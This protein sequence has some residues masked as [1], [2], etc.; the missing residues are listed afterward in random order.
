MNC[1]HCNREFKPKRKWQ[2]FCKK[3]CRWQAW[4]KAHPRIGVENQ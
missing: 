1:K 3:Q 4:D 2:K